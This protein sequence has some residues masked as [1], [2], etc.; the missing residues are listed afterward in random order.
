MIHLYKDE[1]LTDVL[2]GGDGSNPDGD[3][4]NGTYGQSHDRQLFLANEQSPLAE[5]LDASSTAVIIATAGFAND[6]VIIIDGE[7]MK[8]LAGG[9][10]TSL[11]VQRGYAGTTPAV[12]SAE[13]IVYSAYNYTGVSISV[14]DTEGQDE[15]TWYQLALTQTELAAAVP[16]EP[17]PLADKTYQQTLSFW[18]RCTV[19]PGT[20]VQNKT[21]LRLRVGGVEH[22][23]S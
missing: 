5:D 20:P 15:G 7:Q 19:P 22:P 10:T 9:G 23:V 6:E 4:Y 21:D 18:R 2:S 16:G 14:V 17:L 12:H 11:T 8:I 3:T 13:A 1:G